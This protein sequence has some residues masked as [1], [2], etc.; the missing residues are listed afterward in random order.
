VSELYYADPECF[1]MVY[2]KDAY[3]YRFLDCEI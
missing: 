1:E 3:V 2:D